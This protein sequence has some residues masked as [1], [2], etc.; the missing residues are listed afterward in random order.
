[1]SR[2]LFARLFCRALEDRWTP[3]AFTVSNLA[4]AGSGSLRDAILAANANPGPDTVTIGVTGTIALSTGELA[5]TDVLTVTGPGAAALTLTGGTSRVFEVNATGVV[6]IS[7]LTVS[8]CSSSSSGGGIAVSA[9][10]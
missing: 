10:S 2:R 8:N 1:M 5:V 3:A 4:D 9:G 7:G 6:S